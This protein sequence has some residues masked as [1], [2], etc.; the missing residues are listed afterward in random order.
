MSPASA[1]I[2]WTIASGAEAVTARITDSRSRP[3]MT[4]GTAP[5]ARSSSAFAAE[6]VVPVTVWL[7]AIRVGIRVRPTAPA[8]PAM[9]MFMSPRT[10]RP[11]TL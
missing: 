7:S 2:W 1:V 8:A 3:S 10:K 4:A 9:K 6:R 11:V 5:R